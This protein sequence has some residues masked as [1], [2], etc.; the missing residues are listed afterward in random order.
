MIWALLSSPKFFP[1]ANAALGFAAAI[2][3]AFD[4]SPVKAIYWGAGSFLTVIITYFL[5]G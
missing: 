5:K 2:R 4:G 1:L 3:Y